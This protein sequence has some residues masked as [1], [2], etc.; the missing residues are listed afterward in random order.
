MDNYQTRAL[1]GALPFR[2]DNVS[3]TSNAPIVDDQMLT[4]A[5]RTLDRMPFFGLTEQFALSIALFR[6][7]I[8]V[9]ES[10]NGTTE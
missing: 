2:F 9:T 1:A 5:K 8:I 6:E 3:D 10:K 7:S 4:K